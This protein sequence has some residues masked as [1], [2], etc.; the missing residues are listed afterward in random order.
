MTERNWNTY[1]ETETVPDSMAVGQG[2]ADGI[3]T[4]EK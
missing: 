3:P 4:P 2:I 1:R